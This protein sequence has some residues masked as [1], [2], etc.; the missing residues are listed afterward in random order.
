M[1][2]KQARTGTCP[3]A[4][5]NGTPSRSWGSAASEPA[6]SAMLRQ[7]AVAHNALTAIL[8]PE[9]RVLGEKISDLGRYGL[10]QQPCANHIAYN[11]SYPAYFYISLKGL[12]ARSQP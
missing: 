8:S 1:T 9:A 7:M 10:G 6:L 5:A 11:W 2:L 3:R 4:A 12:A